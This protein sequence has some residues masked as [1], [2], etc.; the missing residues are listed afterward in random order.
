MGVRSKAWRKMVRRTV[1]HLG[2]KYKVTL[3][4]KTE[5][6]SGVD[7]TP[8]V[9]ETK[10]V[11]AVVTRFAQSDADGEAVEM[12]DHNL[13]VE[14]FTA[15]EDFDATWTCEAPG[16]FGESPIQSVRTIASGGI[17]L[18]YR[19]HVRPGL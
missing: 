11:F 4:R 5:V 15:D 2:D 3:R 17:P 9:A 16:L 12:G 7:V 19:V 18:G 13:V 8:T 14:H 1:R 6:D 10:E